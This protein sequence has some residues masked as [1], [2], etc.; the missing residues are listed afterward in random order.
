MTTEIYPCLLPFRSFTVLDSNDNPPLFHPLVISV[1]REYNQSVTDPIAAVRCTDLD[2]GS[3]AQLELEFAAGFNYSYSF[4]E[5]T[6]GQ[7]EINASLVALSPP[8][9]GLITFE[10]VCADSGNTSLS[11]TALVS[12][13]VSRECYSPQLSP[14]YH[15][16]FP[17]DIPT[18]TIVVRPSAQFDPLCPHEFHIL[19]GQVGAFA[20]NKTEGYIYVTNPLDFETLPAY[21]ISISLISLTSTGAKSFTASVFITLTN[22]NDNSPVIEPALLTLTLPENTP[23]NHVIADYSCSDVD[24]DSLEFSKSGDLDAKFNLDGQGVLTLLNSLDFEVIRVY[25]LSISCYEVA[26][27]GTIHT[28]TAQLVVLVSAVNDN[29]PSFDQS[30]YTDT[31]SENTAIGTTVLSVSAS[32]N[33]LTTPHNKVSYFHSMLLIVIY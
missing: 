25:D 20:I 33:D 14:M 7:G 4:S 11:S 30:T 15:A 16:T 3:N 6:G 21:E 19:Y 1:S 29:E 5:Q 9:E 18:G 24:H 31:V 10:I 8:S 22:V 28:T 12:I 27:S 23:V 32:D 13:L 26:A 17:E 2:E